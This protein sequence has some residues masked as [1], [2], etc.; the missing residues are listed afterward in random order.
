VCVYTCV[1]VCV[2]LCKQALCCLYSPPT[3]KSYPDVLAALAELPCRV[4]NGRC[5]V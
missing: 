5:R 3:A 2:V 4:Q 1:C